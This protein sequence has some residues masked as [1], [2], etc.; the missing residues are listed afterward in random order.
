MGKS[1]RFKAECPREVPASEATDLNKKRYK[2]KACR[3]G[4]SFNMQIWES[5][6]Q[7]ERRYLIT[8]LIVQSL[9]I[10]VGVG[11]EIRTGWCRVSNVYWPVAVGW[12]SAVRRHP[13]LKM[14]RL[15]IRELFLNRMKCTP[16]PVRV[17][18]PGLVGVVC[19]E[20][21]PSRIWHTAIPISVFSLIQ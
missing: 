16:Y 1:L 11:C 12:D 20:R 5:V 10:K 8:C 19:A 2:I 13:N 3:I 9:E 6:G 7:T 18:H 14:S 15:I 4:R 17:A 21:E